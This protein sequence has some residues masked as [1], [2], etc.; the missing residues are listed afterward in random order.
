MR[1]VNENRLKGLFQQMV[2]IYSPSG[3]EQEITSSI[4]AYLDEH[5][6][7]YALHPVSSGRFNI[8]LGS[9]GGT[10]LLGHIDTVAAYDFESFEFCLEDGICC[11]LG[12][13]DMK[14]GCAALLEAWIT[15]Y[16]N[17]DLPQ[18]DVMLALVVGEEETSDGTAALLERYRF[19]EALIAEP[20]ALKV[21]TSHYGYLELI[22]DLY[23]YRQHA[24]IPAREQHA[25]RSMM[26]LLL[27]LEKQLDSGTDDLV[28]NIR[29]LYSS[30][31]GFAVPG[32]CSATLDVH[33][34]P[35]KDVQLFSQEIIRQ[36]G[37]L[38]TEYGITEWEAT[39]PFVA[40][41]YL[42]EETDLQVQLQRSSQKELVFGQF[43][44]HS[45]ANL[46]F[47]RGCSPIIYGPGDLSY[48][49]TKDEQVSLEQVFRAAEHYCSLLEH[50]SNPGRG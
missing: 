17:G 8:E 34:P 11:G 14:G 9:P 42:L 15:S 35:Q 44:S 5:S 46:L 21:C 33:L 37:Q 24:A 13:A 45:D 7:P 19:K 28:M 30:Q 20:T 41:G 26:R 31:A 50:I 43:R 18:E 25:I 49:H 16:E 6:I 29:D 23:G 3:K 12:T 1:R 2:D 10:L 39:T 47:E 32:R 27:D 4:A 48:A 22:I 36:V 40:Q 38:V